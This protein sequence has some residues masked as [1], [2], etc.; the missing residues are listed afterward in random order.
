MLAGME[1]MMEWFYTEPEK[2]KDILHH[3]MDFQLGIAKHYLQCGIELADF[4]DDLG[5]QHSLLLSPAI[6]REFLVPEYQRLISLYK[7]RG[8]LI[9]FHSCGHIEP[10][11]DLFIELGVDILNPIQATANDLSTVREKT[12]G[13]MALMGGVSSALLMMASPEEIQAETIRVMELLG[14]DGGYLCCADQ[15]MPFPPENLEALYRTVEQYGK[16]PLDEK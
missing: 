16:Y 1:N 11:L 3:I 12:R 13:R 5:T 7:S 15:Y 2:A 6:I 4:G 14:R 10:L 9:N 8:V